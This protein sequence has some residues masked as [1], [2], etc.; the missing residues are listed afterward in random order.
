LFR[1][2]PF[3]VQVILAGVLP[4]AFGALCGYVLGASLVW[5]NVLMLVAGLGGVGGGFEH[6]GAREAAVRGIAAGV[7][8]AAALLAMF[9]LRGVP[10]LTPLPAPVP[11]MAVVYAV[12]GVPVGMLG[13][14]LR[15]RAETRRAAAA[16]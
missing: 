9:E 2:R 4:I 3:A 6:V 15:A 7:L 13:G 8:F 1:Q 5:F 12:M 10:A 14:W 11:M 16:G